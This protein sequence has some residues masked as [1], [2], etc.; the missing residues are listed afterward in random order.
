MSDVS[1]S[2]L[3]PVKPRLWVETL[4]LLDSLTATQPL[5]EIPLRRGLNLIV[6]PPGTGS[7]GHG[8]GK[9]AFCQLLRFVL[10]DPLWSD[11]STLRDELLHSRELK[12]GAAAARVH[13]GGETWTVLKPWLHQKHYRASCTA[14][15]RQL[16]V[17]DAENEFAAYQAALRR[18]LVEVLP[19]QELPGSEQPIEWHQILAWCSRDQNARYQNYYQWRAD[20]A[21]FSWPAKSPAA[22]I[23]IVLGLLPDGTALRELDGTAKT[24]E[25]HKTDLQALREEPGR[26]LKHVRRQLARRLNVSVK[27]PF[28]Q[29]GLLEQPNLIGLAKQRHDTYQQELLTIDAER[30]ELTAQR[31]TWM[32]KRAPLKAGID[33]LTNEIKQMEALAAG[34]IQEVERLQKEASSLQHQLPTRCDAGNRL[35]RDCSHVM[36]RIEQTQIDRKQRITQHQRAKETL[37]SELLPLRR[38]LA[39]LEA[40]AAPMNEQL[41]AIDQRADALTTRHAQSLS[42]DQLLS[43]AIEDYELYEDIAT[44]KSSSPEIATLER[45]L[46]SIQRRHGQL[47]I[48]L[49]KERDAVTG[50]HHVISTAMQA[51]AKSLPSFHW[52]VLSDDNKHRNRPFQMGPMHSTTF[53]VLEILAGDIA[54]LIDSTSP[55]SF[56]PGFLLHDSPREAE[57]SESMLWA[58]LGHVAS[59]ESDAF[60]Y[61]VTTSTEPAEAFKPFER[62]RLSSDSEDG[63]LLRRRVGEE[64]RPLT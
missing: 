6:S 50:R 36:E 21:G 64:Q 34:D 26:L 20:G 58:L 12:E 2:A 19:V 5:R 47:Q 9:T 37:E 1:I 16:A 27:T 54:C 59:G 49:V 10:D 18:H 24:L 7:S 3:N 13:V 45:Q 46:E 22:L 29:D 62:L 56:H 30:Q 43:D 42:A 61:I 15:W 38:R 63:L 44:G 35:L 8:V 60:Q 55:E 14:D 28:R 57:M 48:Q 32:E 4:W 52:G 17:N 11:G 39:E 51:V 23:Q 40:E 31:Q 25:K 41:T 53:K 33:L